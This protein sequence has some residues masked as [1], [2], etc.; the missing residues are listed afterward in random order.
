MKLDRIK[1]K[2]DRKAYKP[3]MKIR[4]KKYYGGNRFKLIPANARK[5]WR[6]IRSKTNG[7]IPRL[8]D[9][10][11]HEELSAVD[12]VQQWSNVKAM[13]SF[14][15]AEHDYSRR[16]SSTINVIRTSGKRNLWREIKF[17]ITI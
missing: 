3:E 2:E 5:F 1:F 8:I 11:Y 9:A 17:E 14:S 15:E 7:F 13:F 4:N 10:G 16:I 12:T 6:R